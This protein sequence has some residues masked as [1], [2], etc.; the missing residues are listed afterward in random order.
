MGDQVLLSTKNLKLKNDERPD[1]AKL[2]P[3][4]VGPYTILEKVGKVAYRMDLNSGTKVHPVLHVSLLFGCKDPGKYPGVVRQACPKD[5][6][7]KDPI[8]EVDRII[9]HRVLFTGGRRSVSCPDC[10]LLPW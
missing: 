5:W 2:L 3:K 4:Y 10:P 7:D 9:Q 8:F 1:G 6:L